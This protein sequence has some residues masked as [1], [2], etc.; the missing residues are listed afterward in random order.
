MKY[1]I[2]DPRHRSA[3][4][5]DASDGTIA[6]RRAGLSPTEVDHGTVVEAAG[7][8]PGVGIIVAKLGMFVPPEAQSYF[9]INRRLYAGAA[10]LYGFDTE[11]Q[12]MDL[13][14]F[15]APTWLHNQTQVEMAI[16]IGTVERPEMAF[17][18]NVYWRWPQPRPTEAERQAVADK[19]IVMLRS[20]PT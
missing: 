11:G 5:V 20:L 3:S 12:T 6:M 14:Y 10:V 19:M 16:A 8:Q 1:V 15:P 9:A 13:N 4:I 17:K 7:R 2:V 18:G